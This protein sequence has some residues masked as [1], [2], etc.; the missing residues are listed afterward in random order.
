[1][2]ECTPLLMLEAVD[3]VG[4]DPSYVLGRQSLDPKDALRCYPRTPADGRIDWSLKPIDVLR[5]INASNKPYSGAFGE[6]EKEKIIIWDAQLVSDGEIFNA[7]PGQV[8]MAGDG[9]IDIACGSGKLRAL[10]VEFRGKVLTPD[11]IIKST[12]RRLT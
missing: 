7:V 9:F 5:L 3:Q 1:M 11:S 4:C 8:T 10:C 12:R 6:L 2:E